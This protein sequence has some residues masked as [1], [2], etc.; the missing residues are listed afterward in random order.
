MDSTRLWIMSCPHYGIV[1]MRYVEARDSGRVRIKCCA[2][3]GGARS[4][5]MALRLEIFSLQNC[6]GCDLMRRKT[7]SHPDVLKEIQS[8]WDLYQEED[9]FAGDRHFLWYPVN[10]ARDPE[11]KILRIEEGFIPAYEFM[12]FLRLAEAQYLIQRH[13]YEASWTLLENTRENYPASGL[14]PECLYYL[15]VVAHLNDNPRAT[16]KV[17]RVLRERYKD[18]AWAHKVMLQW[19]PIT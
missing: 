1:K 19:P 11:G 7:L 6:S 5:K 12:V 18:S 3:K 15:G 14:I 9:A 2:G 13:E 8:K 10:F 16:A 17:W 4:G